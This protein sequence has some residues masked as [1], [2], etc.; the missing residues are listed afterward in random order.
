MSDAEMQGN[1]GHG[2]DNHD[3]CLACELGMEGMGE[4]LEQMIEKFGHAVV[5]TRID[6]PE[7]ELSLSFTVGLSRQGLPELMAFALPDHVAQVMLNASADRLREGRLPTDVGLS[8]IA[9]P[10]DVVF[11]K[12]AIERVREVSLAL[13]ALA[14]VDGPEVL[15]MVWPDKAGCFPWDAG[16][17]E[18]LRAYQPL[19][20][21]VG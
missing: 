16:F 10:L 19:M 5:A 20:Y 1:D 2:H 9:D 14:G 6:I 4:S 18:T 11:K 21:E 3:G 7:G 8:E 13:E 12:A 17:D 15:Q